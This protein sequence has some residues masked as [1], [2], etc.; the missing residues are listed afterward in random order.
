MIPEEIESPGLDNSRSS[1]RSRKF[2]GNY[3][4]SPTALDL[5]Q[6]EYSLNMGSHSHHGSSASTPASPPTFSPS[7]R[8]GPR[9]EDII[10]LDDDEGESSKQDA[11]PKPGSCR[12]II[13][14]DRDPT[15]EDCDR[16]LFKQPTINLTRIDETT[17]SN[18]FGQEQDERRIELDERE[19]QLIERENAVKLRE[20]LLDEK[21]SLFNDAEDIGLFTNQPSNFLGM[22]EDEFEEIWNTVADEDNNAM[23]FDDIP[24]IK[25][26]SVPIDI[27]DIQ[28]EPP[29]A[30]ANVVELD[31]ND[32]EGYEIPI[33]S[34]PVITLD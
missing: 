30:E 5:T 33:D 12:K 28:I 15:Q 7:S 8:C 14:P 13:F 3:F 6:E 26:E 32:F 23:D 25:N 31:E 29:V 22:T 21:E 16:V 20:R 18:G 11:E 1:G 24:S 27:D 9:A 17:P 4:F 2:S 34:I 19:R 10:L